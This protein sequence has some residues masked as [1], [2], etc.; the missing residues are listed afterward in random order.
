MQ[1]V[2]VV[3]LAEAM[4][5]VVMGDL[6]RVTEHMVALVQE[7]LLEAVLPA[8]V[9]IKAGTTLALEVV[10]EEE[11]VEV[12]SMGADEDMVPADITRMEDRKLITKAVLI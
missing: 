6:V 5:L 3:A 12:P 8:L 2:M 9:H 11:L 4:I 1:V 7:L 10:M